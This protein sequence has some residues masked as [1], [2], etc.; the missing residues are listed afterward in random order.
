VA[1]METD[2]ASYRG[3][4]GGPSLAG[5]FTVHSGPAVAIVAGSVS[6]L[7]RRLRT[8]RRAV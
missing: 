2:P 8:R 4:W 7:R 6:W 1:G 5:M 3:D